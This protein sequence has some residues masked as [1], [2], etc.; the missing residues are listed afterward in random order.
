MEKQLFVTSSV[1]QSSKEDLEGAGTLRWVG[2]KLYQWVKNDSGGTVAAGEVVC[3]DEGSSDGVE[4]K[5]V[6][7]PV[8]ARLMLAAGIVASTSIADESYGWIL[9]M[10]VADNAVVQHITTTSYAAGHYY[11]PA[12]GNKFLHHGATNGAEYEGRVFQVLEVV[13]SEVTTTSYK[14]VYVNCL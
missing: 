9:R 1:T 7:A 4:G 8:T 2:N 10:G 14:K 5:T 12:T 3:F 11:D 13:A 6:K